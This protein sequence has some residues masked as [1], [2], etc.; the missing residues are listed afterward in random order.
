MR[1]VAGDLDRVEVEASQITAG[2]DFAFYLQH[3][4][5]AFATIG[6]GD[7][8]WKN[9]EHIGPW[10]VHS[11]YFD[12]NDAIL[13]TGASYWAALVEDRLKADA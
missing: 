6:N 1:V 12:F 13:P 2:E 5:G 11:P 7:N 4:P 9:G 8:G 3:A 10:A